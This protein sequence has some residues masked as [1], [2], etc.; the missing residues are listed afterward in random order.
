[1][2]IFIY[3]RDELN[4]SLKKVKWDSKSSSLRNS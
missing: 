4:E 1:M 2:K 3:W